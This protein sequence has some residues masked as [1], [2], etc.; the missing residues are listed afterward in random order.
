MAL[1]LC[2]GALPFI[3]NA[4]V[5]AEE[6]T[7]QETQTGSK[8]LDDPHQHVGL[9]YSASA[10]FQTAYL[11]RGIYVGALNTQLDASIGYGGLYFEA[12]WNIG[13]EDWTFQTFQPE[14]DLILGFSRWGL[15]ASV[16][17]IHS[18]NCPFFDFGLHPGTPGNALEIDLRYTISSK[19]PLSFLWATRVAANDGYLNEAGEAVRAFS[20]YAEV[21]YT[22]QLRDGFSLYYAFGI[23][24]WRSMYTGFERGF[25]VQN[26]EMRLS[27]AWSLSEHCGL[28]LTGQLSVS[29]MAKINVINPNIALCI[30]LK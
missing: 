8:W 28:S 17:F 16:V 12:W 13:A 19:L 11:W 1:A 6:T 26:I 20:S 4:G 23:T 18:F 7:S 22:Q 14:V 15:N 21:S 2:V 5:R 24:P 27:K 30:F 29:P 9:T 10:K 25:A 3:F